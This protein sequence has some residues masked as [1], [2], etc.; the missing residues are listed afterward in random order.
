MLK[1]LF[2]FTIYK[3]LQYDSVCPGKP[4]QLIVILTSK[5]S[6]YL[7]EAAGLAHKHKTRL[8]INRN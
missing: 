2:K 4:L 5:A 8:E 3:C 1:N 6:A 7:S